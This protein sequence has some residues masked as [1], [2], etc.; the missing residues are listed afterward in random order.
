MVQSPVNDHTV[1]VPSR[2]SRPPDDMDV[3]ATKEAWKN[4]V[5][6]KISNHSKVA[7]SSIL[8]INHALYTRKTSIF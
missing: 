7:M 5:L 1:G 2:V 4:L 3:K 8:T 6:I